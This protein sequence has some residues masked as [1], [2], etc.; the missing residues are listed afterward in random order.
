HA[1]KGD[2]VVQGQPV[3]TYD[4]ASVE[5]A[6]YPTVVPV[7]VMDARGATVDELAEPSAPVS[8]MRPLFTVTKKK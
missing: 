7:V 5:A 3:I 2:R 6:G 1:A 4:V 8:T